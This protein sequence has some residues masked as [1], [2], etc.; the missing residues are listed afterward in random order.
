LAKGIDVTRSWKAG[1]A[2]VQPNRRPISAY[3]L[4]GALAFQG[5]SG[6]AGGLGLIVD[7]SGAMIGLPAAWLEGSVFSDYLIPGL[8]L[9][10][11]LGMVP[12]FVL[13]GLWAG[14][15]WSRAA[16]LWVGIALIAWIVVEVIVVG[17]QPAPP[18]QLT[19]GALGAIIIGLTR[20]VQRA[21]RKHSSA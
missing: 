14:R 17:Y 2:N 19:Y 11:V 13:W 10:S 4:M 12:S 9:V 5:L 7:P 20:Y 15:S 6:L 3:L 8:I 18:L 21:S 1:G 16:A